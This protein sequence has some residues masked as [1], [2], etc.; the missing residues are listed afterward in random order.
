MIAQPENLSICNL[1]TIEFS[2]KAKYS[3]SIFIFGC[4]LKK[5][6]D[7]I[8]STSSVIVQLMPIVPS[9]VIKTS[10]FFGEYAHL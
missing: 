2:T 1:H 3:C 10:P 5:A 7:K 6:Q 4:N 9:F 8:E